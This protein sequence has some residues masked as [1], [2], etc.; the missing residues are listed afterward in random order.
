MHKYILTLVNSLIIILLCSCYSGRSLHKKGQILY[1]TNFEVK[2][3]LVHTSKDSSILHL[4]ADSDEYELSLMAFSTERRMILLDKKKVF[5]NKGESIV[6]IPFKVNEPE[7]F[8][9][10]VIRDLNDGRVF[11]DAFLADRNISSQSVTIRK[12]DGSA[13]VR[14]YVPIQ[15]EI[16]LHHPKEKTI[17]VKYFEK[18]F[19]SAS[20]PFSDRGYKFNPKENFSAAIPVPNGGTVKLEGYGLYFIQTDT[21]FYNGIYINVFEESYPRIS[22]SEQM[23]KSTRYITKL[24]EYKTMKNSGNIKEAIDKFWL[25]KASDK[26]FAKDLIK[27]YYT[28]VQVANR[29]FTTYKEGWKTD[30]GMLYIIFGIPEQIVKVRNKEIWIY[31]PTDRRDGVR[32]EFKRRH[33]QSLLVHMEHFKRPW[34]VE[35]FEWR[36]GILND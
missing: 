15:S 33:G 19:R 35:V 30:R 18:D 26:E 22:S 31:S 25:G 11:R 12:T 32:F 21:S 23:L 27:T 2:H 20:P 1:K 28:R 5:E 4:L 9:E 29:D 10:I 24:D 17:W 6:S 8:L 34:D 16:V 7:Y 3:R 36:K 13:I 14:N